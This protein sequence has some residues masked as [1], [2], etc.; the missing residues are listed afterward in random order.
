MKK[1]TKILLVMALICGIAGGA[2]GIVSLCSGFQMEEFRTALT[3]GRFQMDGG[4]L[5]WT[6]DVGSI[7]TDIT[8]DQVNFEETYSGIESLKLDIGVA[9][10]TFIPSDSEEW[11]VIGYDVPARFRCRQRGKTLDISCRQAFWSFLNFRNSEPELEIWVPQSQ[12]IKEVQIDAGVGD[13]KATE[14]VLWCERLE[15]DCGVGDC[16]IRADIEKN[17]D[18]EGG[19]G[20]VQLELIG[21]EQEFDYEIDCGVGSAT[22]GEKHYSELGNEIKLDNDAGRTIKIDCGVGSVEVQFEE[23][24][25]AERTS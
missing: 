21:Q 12:L 24:E 3:E 5:T 23:R 19:V 4:L 18:I 16:D 1:M 2:F 13:L 11:K 14:G 9:K 20:H 25:A 8:A 17:A 15:I 10:C 6:D 7:V 22:I